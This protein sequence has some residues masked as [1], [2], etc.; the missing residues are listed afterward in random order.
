M[1]VE[2]VPAALAGERLDRIVAFVADISRR[3]RRR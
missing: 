2:I 3:T 1:I